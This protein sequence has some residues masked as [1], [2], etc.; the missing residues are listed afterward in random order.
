[1]GSR[2]G[3]GRWIDG[4]HPLRVQVLHSP[5]D[6]VKHGAGL[7]LR[8]ELLLED[9]IQQLSSAHQLRHQVHLLTV[10]VHLTQKHTHTHTHTLPLP[11]VTLKQ[12]VL[13]TF[14]QK[15]LSF[16]FPYSD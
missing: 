13:P 2:A 7:S 9:P 12:K 1:M 15:Y 5:G 8:E 14:E 3:H 16:S 10:V 11:V 6:G 4:S